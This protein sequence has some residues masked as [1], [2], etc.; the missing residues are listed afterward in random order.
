M[1]TDLLFS[2]GPITSGPIDLVFGD[3]GDGVVPDVEASFVAAFPGFGGQALFAVAVE[4][5]FVA[6][7]PGFAG[8]VGMT[9][10]SDTPRPLVGECRTAWQD[11]ARAQA[12]L[13]GIWQQAQ[14]LSA[15]ADQ[16]WQPARHLTG[17]V[18][19]RWQDGERLATPVA[20]SWQDAQR[21]HRGT[22]VRYQEGDPSLRLAVATAWQDGQAQRV[23]LAQRYQ[24]ALRDRRLSVTTGWQDAT[25]LD[26]QISDTAQVAVP[27]H[28][29]W[30]VRF[31]E[32]MKPPAGISKPPEPPKPDPCYVPPP[33]LAVHLLFEDQWTRSTD[34]L[35]ICVRHGPGPDP[36]VPQYVIPLLRVYMSVHTIKAELLPGNERVQL[37]NITIDA[38][39]DD[40]AWTMS[41]SGPEHLIDQLAPVSGMPAQVRVT[42]DGIEWIFAID[43]P[44]RSRK[45]GQRGVQVRGSSVTS[46]LTEP[47]MPKSM[48][49][50]A[51]ARTAQQLV[52]DALEFT[53]VDIDWNIPD[54]E[55]P[56]GVW[57]FEGTPLAAALR[58]AEAAGAVVR[59]HRTQP[60]LQFDSRFP[61]LPWDWDSATPN[62]AMPSRIITSDEL[63]PA[64]NPP[65][66]AVYV[67][68]EE[69][70]VR[71]HVVRTGTAEAILANQVTDPLITD[72]TVARERGRAILGTQGRR[73]NHPMTVPLLT[74]GTNPGLI[75]PGYLIKVTEPSEVW[76]GLVRSI[77]VTAG[78][79]TV[80]Q[81]LK[82]ERYIP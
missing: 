22:E 63:Q 36:E 4:A 59:S 47:F 65:W 50:N 60:R 24:E 51:G 72:Y 15:G 69:Q 64:F 7:F 46:L 79:P 9:Y 56:A 68:G 73:F 67:S 18:V 6:S 14:A 3:D 20:S 70:G 55:V 19:S 53:G 54:W 45:F 44:T 8:Q 41:A 75:L 58:I 16:H 39:D 52:Y 66:E 12:P 13:A 34:L 10:V 5:A 48:W 43:P 77:S 80:R 76:R 29:H 35:F 37:S 81:S 71:G 30:W 40:F 23:S 2:L 1:A 11:A 62:V 21:A 57:N 49:A 26:A 27:L 78:I 82:V 61:H 28:K 74:G 17:G 38:G 33:G 32:G 25:H 31:Q 42:I